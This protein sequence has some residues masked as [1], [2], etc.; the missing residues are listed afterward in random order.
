MDWL[1]KDGNLVLGARVTRT[2]AYGFLSIVLAIY[3][4]LIGFND[5]VIGLVLASTLVNSVIFTL[6]A[7]FYA[8]RLG[9]RNMLVIY[10]A[11]MSISGAIFLATEDYLAL[12]AAA[13]IGTINVTGSET[14]AFLSIEQ[15]LLPQTVSNVRKRNTIFALYNMAGT[16]A[17]SVGI[18][19]SA[20][21]AILQHQFG[22]SQIESIK[23]LFMLYSILGIIVMIIYFMLSKKIELTSDQIAKPLTQVLSPETKKIVG[24]LS[25]LFS[26]DSFAGGFVIQSIVAFWFFT[27]FG[28]DLTTLS[29]IFS[30]AGVLTAFSF[31]AAARIADKIGLVN[32][33]VFTH[34]PSNI[35]LILV[36]FAPTLPLA[37]AFYLGRM[38]LSQMD[39]P[40]RQSYIVS[41]VKEEE[42]TAS[43]GI[44]NISRNISQAVSPSL[45]GYILQALPVLSA[46]FVFGGI[47]KIA[48][49][50][51]LYLNFKN[52]KPAEEET[53]KRD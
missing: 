21:P 6:I 29:Y 48:Y 36:G 22:L 16:F 24:K 53:G 11:L 39:V 25:G 31:L 38:A 12:I 28:L 23:P 44:T 3:L 35:L 2:F 9:R 19:L 45:T 49:D 10:A 41:V 30:I 51:A 4:K 46:P 13:L 8:D 47:L 20:L 52:I 18:L 37:I 43:T 32:T 50:L 7:S 27:K 40:T 26:L 15:A 42:R 33:M 17:M 1:S 5:I 14:G 34:I